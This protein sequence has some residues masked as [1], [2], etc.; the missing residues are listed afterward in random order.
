MNHFRSNNDS[1]KYLRLTPSGCKD[2][3]IVKLEFVAKTKFLC[4]NNT[5]LI[6]PLKNVS[7]NQ[8]EPIYFCHF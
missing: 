2:K 3:V 6:L 8:N 1:L 7:E 5:V 4:N